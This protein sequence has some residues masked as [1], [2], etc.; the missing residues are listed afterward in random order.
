MSDHRFIQN[1]YGENKIEYN[2]RFFE[3][4]IDSQT[5]NFINGY[6]KPN[7]LNDETSYL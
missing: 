1:E 5:P 3:Q 2:S 6:L 7:V 4:E